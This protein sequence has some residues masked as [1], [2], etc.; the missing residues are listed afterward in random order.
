MIKPIGRVIKLVGRV[1]ICLVG[2]CFVSWWLALFSLGKTTL[3]FWSSIHDF[4]NLPAG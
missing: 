1:I 2:G 4:N 3:E